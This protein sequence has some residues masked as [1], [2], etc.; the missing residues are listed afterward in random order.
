MRKI[1]IETDASDT[2]RLTQIVSS[3]PIFAKLNSIL[4]GMLVKEDEGWICRI[5]GDAGST[6]HHNTRE[7]CIRSCM[8]HGYE[9]FVN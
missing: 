8:R 5:G 4:I 2:I 1:I 7:K 6:G 3:E 9:F